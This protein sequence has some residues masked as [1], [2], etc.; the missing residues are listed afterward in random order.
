MVACV[1]SVLAVAPPSV[2]EPAPVTFSVAPAERVSAPDCVSDRPEAMVQVWA[3]PPS[4]SPPVIERFWVADDISM[5]PV[6]TVR[7]LVP[8]ETGPDGLVTATPPTVA[9]VA[10]ETPRFAVDDASKRP[11]SDDPGTAVFQL[12]VVAQSVSTAPV[13]VCVAA[14]AGPCTM[15]VAAARPAM[16]RA[17]RIA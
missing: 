1:S 13:H 15:T 8:I 14:R 4:V 2:A 10:S 5:P 17:Q 3:P 9:G 6:P 12:P 11:T 7:A 16:P